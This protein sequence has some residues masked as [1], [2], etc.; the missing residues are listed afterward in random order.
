MNKELRNTINTN[1]ANI[2]KAHIWIYRKSRECKS[3]N[4]GQL[5]SHLRL[6]KD[7]AIEV[8]RKIVP[9]DYYGSGPVADFV[10]HLG[11][12]VEGNQMPDWLREMLTPATVMKLLRSARQTFLPSYDYVT[13]FR[14]ALKEHYHDHLEERIL[15]EYDHVEIWT[16]SCL[17]DAGLVNPS[18]PRM[19]HIAPSWLKHWTG[20]EKI[21]RHDFES[22]VRLTI[23]CCKYRLDRIDEIPEGHVAEIY[24]RESRV[25]ADNLPESE[26][27]EKVEL[28]QSFVS[29]MAALDLYLIS[30]D[31]QYKFNGTGVTGPAR[32]ILRFALKSDFGTRVEVT[33]PWDK[34]VFGIKR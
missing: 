29:D 25:K 5:A 15:Q 31:P 8:V 20:N 32:A 26:R 17:V 27:A 4:I 19:K 10:L 7:E 12:F 22:N 23:E 18:E 14:R 16:R 28:V 1:T 3:V 2:D 6:S 34:V 30:A 24:Y 9:V 13:E 33:L 11:I 21:V